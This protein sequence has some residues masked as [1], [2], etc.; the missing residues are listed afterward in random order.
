MRLSIRTRFNLIASS[1]VIAVLL[2]FSVYNQVETRKSL[3]NS[4]D[5]QVNAAVSRLANSVPGMLWNYET[6]QIRSVAESEIV[7][8]SIKRIMIFDNEGLKLGLRKEDDGSIGISKADELYDIAEELMVSQ[9]LEFDD[10]GTLNKVGNLVIEVDESG[11]HEALNKALFRELLQL[12]LVVAI[13]ISTIT[14]LLKRV[15]MNRLN[16]VADALHDISQGDGDLTQ[17]L[18]ES[19]DEIGVLSS[20]FNSFV[21]KI[22]NLL[23]QVIGAVEDMNRL[24][25]GLVDV[26]ENTNAGVA[27]QKAETD[28]AATAITEMAASAKEVASSASNAAESARTADTDARN[29][30][31]VLSRT[32]AA[33]DKLVAEVESG[34]T[35]VASLET[36][37]SSITAMIDVIQGIAEQT[38][39]LALNAAI[40]A[41]RAG[42]QGRGFAVVADE[43]RALASKTQSTTEEIREMI[44]N[45]QD[46]SSKAVS[47]MNA[48]KETGTKTIA[49]ADEAEKSL[50]DIVTSI[51]NINEMNSQIA[52]AAEEQ[53]HVAE[54]IGQ[55]VTRV[56]DISNET[57]DGA[58]ETLVK[59]ESSSELISRISSMLSQFKV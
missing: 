45:L 8:D 14:Y 34:S 56:A 33:I 7:S 29:A 11:I 39:L 15:V 13:L 25:E 52:S 22:Q 24:I 31:S 18:K 26:S 19:G 27:R 59:C 44:Q 4:L 42:E 2:S 12:V 20:H 46:G 51:S 49:E 32:I 6:E 41:A 21:E 37:V 9:K 43:V 3:R 23:T 57:A 36:D 40:E 28:Q 10:S 35:V 1:V 30:Q 54:E 50:S 48:G 55:N 17:R 5:A 47:V 53:T 58:S 16:K 38:N